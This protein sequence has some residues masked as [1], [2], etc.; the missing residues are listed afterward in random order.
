MKLTKEALETVERIVLP[1]KA[2]LFIVVEIFVGGSP[3][4]RKALRL[5]ASL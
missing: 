2:L 4:Q 1:D 3:R 5:K